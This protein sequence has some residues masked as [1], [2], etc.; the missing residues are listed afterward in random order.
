M[1]PYR[2]KTLGMGWGF[3]VDLSLQD[4]RRRS[5]GVIS[6]VNRTGGKVHPEK[7]KNPTRKELASKSR[8]K[9]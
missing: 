8:S 1:I 3:M 5:I 9:R 7:E 2:R 4:D 6:Y